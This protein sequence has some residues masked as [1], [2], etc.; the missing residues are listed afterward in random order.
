MK[1]HKCS[2]CGYETQYKSHLESHL[3]KKKP[4]TSLLFK[5]VQPAKTTVIT[6]KAD[7]T[8][9]KTTATTVVINTKE[10]TYCHK[11][12]KRK[13]N[14]TEHLKLN[15]CKEQ[16]KMEENTTN[17]TSLEINTDNSVEILKLQMEKMEKI[18]KIQNDIQNDIM[19]LKQKPLIIQ[20]MNVQHNHFYCVQ[21]DIET[22]E[23][24]FRDHFTTEVYYNGPC[25]AIELL[26]TKLFKKD[27]K[28]LDC[29]RQI[30][31]Y[32]TIPEDETEER[33][34]KDIKNYKTL[35]S[36]GQIYEKYVRKMMLSEIQ[37]YSDDP[38]RQELIMD[39]G[40]SHLKMINNENTWAFNW[41][42]LLGK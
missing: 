34:V 1:I 24:I 6:A 26:N 27:I 3:N 4:C 29:G 12:F 39:I 42:K 20:T 11:I 8:T 5:T 35:N 28:L 13:Y 36:V 19:E 38:K 33:I 40:Q 9:V 10:C 15:R 17:I 14:V 2:K 22:I 32:M 16:K 21:F 41:S 37:K 31:Q 25:A 7:V 23:N 18:E 30:F